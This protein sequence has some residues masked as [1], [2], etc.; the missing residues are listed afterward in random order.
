MSLIGW[1]EPDYSQYPG[2]GGGF[3][4]STDTKKKKKADPFEDSITGVT[5]EAHR[6]QGI[7]DQQRTDATGFMR[8]EFGRA[9]VPTLSDQTISQMFTSKSDEA[10][11]TQMDQEA[12]LRANLGASGITGGGYAAG[13]LS[14]FEN[15]R[16]GAVTDARRSLTIAKAQSDAEDRY[17]RFVNSQ[18]LATQMQ[19]PPSMLGLDAAQFA[20]NQRLAKYGIDKQAKAAKQASSNNLLG[21]IIGGVGSLLGG[22]L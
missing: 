10:A 21:G 19:A 4:T 16:W 14:G 7:E 6:L 20:S 22:F 1:P 12:G 2:F 8:Q 18:V 17:K 3:L 9:N 11:R 13:I 15:Q 5:D